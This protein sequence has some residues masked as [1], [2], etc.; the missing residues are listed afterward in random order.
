MCQVLSLLYSS[1]VSVK[2]FQVHPKKMFRV[3]PC[4]GDALFEPSFPLLVLFYPLQELYPPASTKPI[5]S[6]PKLVMR[7]KLTKTLPRIHIFQHLVP[8]LYE[9]CF[10]LFVYETDLALVCLAYHPNPITP[11][12]LAPHYHATKHLS[13]TR[14]LSCS[15][16]WPPA[17]PPSVTFI[18]LLVSSNHLLC[19]LSPTAALSPVILT[20]PSLFPFFFFIHVF[21]PVLHPVLL[22]PVRL[23]Q[24]L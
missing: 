22:F 11:E 7:G 24:Y 13:S 20:L 9:R 10:I 21:R 5:L 15:T 19:F 16:P 4:D 8:F 2:R 12:R 14:V 23:S 1:Q 3:S 17:L 18:P 6:A